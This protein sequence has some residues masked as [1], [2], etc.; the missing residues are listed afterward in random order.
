MMMEQSNRSQ[1]LKSSIDRDNSDNPHAYDDHWTAMQLAASVG[2]LETLNY[3]IRSDQDVNYQHE[4]SQLC[5]C[6][7]MHIILVG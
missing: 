1:Y 3:C 5:Q 4:V 6:V 2:D 7:R